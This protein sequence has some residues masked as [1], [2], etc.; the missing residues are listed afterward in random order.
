MLFQF[1][2]FWKLI[3]TLI[4]SWVLYFTFGF[5]LCIVTLLSILIVF[6]NNTDE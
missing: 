1:G 3:L 2:L 6:Q 4:F 5:E